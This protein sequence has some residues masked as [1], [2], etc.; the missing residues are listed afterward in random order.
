MRIKWSVILLMSLVMVFGA[1][2]SSKQEKKAAKE[3]SEPSVEVAKPKPSGGAPADALA[4]VGDR[5]I[6][7]ADYEKE[8]LRFSPKLAETEPGRRYIVN[9]QVENIL[10]GKEAEARGWTKDPLMI[11]KIEEFTRSL[12]RNTLFQSL[13]ETQKPISDAEARKYFQEHEEEFIQPDRVHISLIELGP[14]RKKDIYAIYKDLKAGKDFAQLAELKSTNPSSKNGG[15]LGLVTRKQYKHLTD[16]AFTM[17]PGE[18]SKPFKSPMG[19]DIIKVSGFVKKQNLTPEEEIRRAKARLQAMEAS[20]AYDALMKNLKQK[21]PV[22]LYE[23]RIR[24]IESPPQGVDQKQ[25]PPQQPAA[26]KSS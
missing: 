16:V 13:K 1:C 8:L 24:L 3:P 6:R 12:Y 23:D 17:K 22:V 21:Y 18:I 5:Y 4:K 14:D 20:R 9:Q 7:V 25:K 2:N 15:D 19:W 11:S 26:E 10:L